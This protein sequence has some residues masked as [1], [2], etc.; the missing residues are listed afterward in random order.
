LF[1]LVVAFDKQYESFLNDEIAL[2]A[3]K[4]RTLHK[5]RKERRRSPRDCFDC[6]DTTHFIADCPMRKKLDSS[7]KYNNNNNDDDDNDND[8]SN[9]KGDNKKKYRFTKKKKKFQNIM[10]RACAALSDFDFS[11][12]DSSRSEENEKVKRKQDDFTYLCLMD[13]SLR[14]I[15]NSDSDVSDDLS[16]ESLSFRVVELKSILC[17][18][19]KLLCKVFCESKKLN[20]EFESAF[21]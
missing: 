14:N 4:F 15:F 19:D 8:D 20:L 11:S 17:N 16:H 5:F 12:N 18:Q 21:F 3:R 6:S 9:N 7:N 1:S 2:L 13:K 10:S